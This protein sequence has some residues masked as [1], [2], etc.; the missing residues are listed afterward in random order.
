LSTGIW[1]A[2]LNLLYFTNVLIEY[3]ILYHT[4]IWNC[5]QFFIFYQPSLLVLAI[6]ISFLTALLIVYGRLSADKEFLALQASGFSAG[7]LLWPLAG[8]SVVLS[9]FMVVFMDIV[10]PWGNTSFIKLD[11]QIKIKHTSIVVKERTFI[12]DFQGYILYVDQKEEG[13]NQLKKVTVLLLDEKGTPYRV[14]YANEGSLQQDSKYHIILRLEKGVMQ[15]LGTK[16]DPGYSNLLELKFSQCDLDLS[17]NSQ[18]FGSLDENSSRNMKIRELA[19][20]IADEKTKK[21][22]SRYD[23]VEFNKKF[24]LP[25]SSLAFVFIGIPLGL[26]TRGGSFVG[27]ILAVVL[28]A[29]YD[30]FLMLG[31]NGGF[32]G[33]FSPF[34]SMW[35]PNYFLVMVGILLIVW[36]DHRLEITF[37]IRGWFKKHPDITGELP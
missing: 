20:K 21:I 1:L 15:Q 32:L 8:I 27:P 31:D 9:L 16:I 7:S 35:V 37:F 10:L 17:S 6:P 29:L 3:L 22:D 24:S 23:E 19:K 12:K 13:T 33:R 11:Y 28:V 4:G 25:F 18:P 2:L 34:L 14:V 36:I 26:I 5:L 30:G